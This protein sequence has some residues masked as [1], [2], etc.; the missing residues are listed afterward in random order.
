MQTDN[1]S[2]SKTLQVVRY[3]NIYGIILYKRIIYH[4]K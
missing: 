3:D 1:F 2:Y 4:D